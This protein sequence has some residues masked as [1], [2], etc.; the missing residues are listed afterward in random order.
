MSNKIEIVL[1]RMGESVDEATI[2]GWLKN[3]G[4]K[5]NEDDLI[6]E[7][8]TDKVDSEVPSE[9]SG[10]LIK[11]LCDVNDVVKV[12]DPIAIIEA[13]SVE[14]NLKKVEPLKKLDNL[15]K[16]DSG[17]ID[18]IKKGDS[19][20]QKN[21]SNESSRIYSP[22]VK[23]ISKQEG[24]SI[25][26]LD[27]I[28][29]SGKN[30]R[31]TKND[32]L[33]YISNSETT[34]KVSENIL[35]NELSDEIVE[36]SRMEKLISDH[37]ISSKE[38][39]AHVQAFIEAD[40]TNLWNWREKN[41]NIFF[42]RENEKITFTPIFIQIVAQVL[43]EFPMLNISLDNY[44]IIKKKS[45][46]IG[47]ATALSDGNLIVPVIKN[48][49]QFSLLGLVKK[50]NDLA[51]RARNG[52]LEPD[53]VKDG[54]YTISNVGVFDTLM[55]TPIINQPQV[56]ILAFG[57]INKKPSVIETDQGDFIGIRHKI[58]LS[59]SFDHRIVN[60]AMG[61]MFIKRIKELIEGWDNTF[62]I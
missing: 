46:N 29:G 3:E 42:D 21:I 62:S 25:N 24:I 9:F 23:N 39:S 34:E 35:S 58:I 56:G 31:I 5:I 57:A 47:M 10:I 11:K 15:K 53:E 28:K 14:P 19:L 43:R 60:G 8:A 30:G 2:T 36:M 49:D 50:V 52:N 54:T 22:L 27:N 61:G 59:H 55:G 45:I 18:F 51:K 13:D 1:P 6:V 4:D 20:I 40:I 41:K 17:P 38:K 26:E 37:M 33:S 44:N 7:I 16:I 48:A 32:L 12:G